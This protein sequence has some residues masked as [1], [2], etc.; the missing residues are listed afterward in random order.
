MHPHD[1]ASDRAQVRTA[2]LLA[3]GCPGRRRAA[4]RSVPVR[5]R[6]RGRGDAYA[7]LSSQEPGSPISLD[8]I[9]SRCRRRG[10]DRHGDECECRQH[11]AHR[12]QD[13][14]RQPLR[15]VSRRLVPVTQVI[16]LVHMT[17]RDP[18]E[19]RRQVGSG[20]STIVP[21]L[22]VL[23]ARV[24][25]LAAPDSAKRELEPAPLFVVAGS[26]EQLRSHPDN[27]AAFT[28]DAFW[29]FVRADRVLREA[30]KQAVRWQMLA[31]NP[32]DAV[33]PPRAGHKEMQ[34]LD[35]TGTAQLLRSLQ[36]TRFHLA[37]Q[38]AVGT[39]M[40]RGELPGL[41]WQDIDLKT[42]KLAVRQNQQQTSRGLLFKSPKTA[43]GQRSI[44]LM[45]STVTALR[46]YKRW[47]AE[48]RVE[49]GPAYQAQD[50]VLCKDDGS[51]WTP[52]CFSAQWHKA[53]CATER[54][55]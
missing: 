51:P 26:S 25:S 36:G 30:L 38:L 14:H 34:V 48:M 24:T 16:G 37:A 33:K 5:D 47:Q 53:L 49:M 52:H 39:G 41:R 42:G 27:G 46:R 8:G 13:E 6:S 2:L 4:V 19:T 29:R 20:C 3:A 45:P 31:V 54:R 28:S 55:N 23:R 11:P 43:K 32:A 12:Q 10:G 35:Q 21:S 18:L 9:P 22:S 40:R 50:L 15:C 1:P 7:F 44:S 17:Q